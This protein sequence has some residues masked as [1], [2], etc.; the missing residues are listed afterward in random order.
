VIKD[1]HLQSLHYP[2]APL[3]IFLDSRDFA[4]LSIKIKTA[5]IPVVLDRVKGIITKYAPGAPFSYSFFDEVFERAYSAERR[6][7]KIFGAFSVLAIFIACLGLFGLTA[8]AAEQRTREVGIR[9]VLGE[10]VS[11]LFALLSREFLLWV[12]LANLLA[13]PTAY[14]AMNKWLEKFAYRTRLGIAPFLLSAAAF[15]QSE[16]NGGRS[17]MPK[18]RNKLSIRDYQEKTDSLVLRGAPFI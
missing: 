7:A 5:D 8:F 3:Y 15:I 1:F 13:W 4:C 2:I 12:L 18:I 10:S 11:S 16:S 14:F 6:M 17:L 9:K